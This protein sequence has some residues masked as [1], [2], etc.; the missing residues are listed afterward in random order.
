[1][2]Y[3]TS[4]LLLA[5]FGFGIEVVQYYLPGR[6]FSLIDFAADLVGIIVGIVLFKLIGAAD[7]A[8]I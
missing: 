7:Q 2:P 6:I 4:V 1:M 8:T 3:F 5:A